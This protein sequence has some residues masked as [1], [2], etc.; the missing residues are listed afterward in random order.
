MIKELHGKVYYI[1]LGKDETIVEKVKQFVL[2]ERALANEV[3]FITRHP[4]PD[5]NFVLESK[6]KVESFRGDKYSAWERVK[7]KVYSLKRH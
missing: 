3:F 5:G 1:D 7:R 6:A 2:E 4:L